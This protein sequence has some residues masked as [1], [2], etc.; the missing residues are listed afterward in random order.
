MRGAHQDCPHASGVA[1][2]FNPRRLRLEFGVGLCT[3]ECHRSC[4]VAGRR[5]A[6]AFRT[7]RQ[8]CTCPGAERERIR[9]DEAGIDYPGFREQWE[10]HRRDSQ[11]AREVFQAVRA[12]ARGK[13]REEIRQLYVAE[14][15]S[16]GLTVPPEEALEAIVDWIRGNPLPG[17]RLLGRSLVEMRRAM[18]KLARLFYPRGKP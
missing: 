8:S 14:L 2:G 18:V 6:V 3:C 17:A 13:T 12:V 5:R 11:A 4:P 16:R 7:W 10:Q 15:R 9:L 1:G